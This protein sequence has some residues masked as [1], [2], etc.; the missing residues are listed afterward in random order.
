MA[1]REAKLKFTLMRFKGFWN[2]YKRSKRGTLGLCIVVFYIA[3]ALLAPFITHYDPYAP[4]LKGYYPAGER[5]QIAERLSKPSW[6]K[7]L[8]GGDAL[9]EN[10]FPVQDHQLSTLESIQAEWNWIS[11]NC[12]AGPNQTEGEQDDGC[13]EVNYTNPS[14]DPHKTGYAIVWHEFQYPYKN[15]PQS[16]I[17]HISMFT[18]NTTATS[19]KVHIADDAGTPLYTNLETLY[20]SDNKWRHTYIRSGVSPR[21]TSKTFPEPGNYSLQVEVTINGEEDVTVRLDNI[22]LLIYGEVFGILGSDGNLGKPRDILSTLIYGTRI[23]LMVGLLSAGI[24]TILGLF[25]GLVAGFVGGVTDEFIMRF[26]D[27]LLVLP[28]LPLL[29]VLIVVTQASIWNLILL[30][31]FMGWMSFSRQVRSMVLS[32]RERPFIEAARAVG[33]S[34][35][36]IIVRHIIPNVFALVYITLATSVPGAI[37]SEASISWLG[38]FDPTI[39][40][41]GRMLFE[42]TNSGVVN[43]PFGDYWFWMIPPG[44]A[45]M[46][47]AMAFILMGYSLDEILNPKLRQRR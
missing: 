9:S 19:I 38:L 40:S 2:E 27:F 13:I 16:F 18:T 7:S 26:A 45:I 43:R 6:Y 42:F 14:G 24:S 20:L 34:N 35:S 28:T 10:L 22:D 39:V 4:T 37:I 11:I 44:I 23:S 1:S 21:L 17:I 15:P 47:L 12:T 3:L 32:I 31:S 36:Y 25:L 33:G 41:W 29:I 30:L 46:F 8:P 5:P